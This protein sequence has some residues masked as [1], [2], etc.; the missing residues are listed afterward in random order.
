M[1]VEVQARS[2]GSDADRR[3]VELVPLK[4]GPDLWEQAA[5]AAPGQQGAGLEGE[6]VAGDVLGAK[7][8]GAGQGRGPGAQVLEGHPEDQVEVDVA[9]AR[10]AR[11]GIGP[12]GL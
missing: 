3:A 11:Q 1:V 5:L 8:G 2:G 12:L 4:V 6:R 9:E 7:G 10:G